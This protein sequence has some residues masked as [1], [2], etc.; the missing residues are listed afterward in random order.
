MPPKVTQFPL[1]L[2]IYK[3]NG[4]LFS[5]F[6]KFSLF[7]SFLKT[8]KGSFP[9][10]HL[11][12]IMSSLWE[13]RHSNKERKKEKKKKWKREENKEYRQGEG[14]GLSWKEKNMDMVN[15]ELYIKR[16][17]MTSI[18]QPCALVV[19][20]RTHYVNSEIHHAWVAFI[21]IFTHHFSHMANT[22][23]LLLK[24]PSKSQHTKRKRGG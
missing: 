22:T 14:G 3:K 23:K 11:T 8:M 13:L 15:V 9:T 1:K 18:I 10:P 7:F 5:M 6:E 17:C 2:S 19:L 21:T 12:W 4:K 24:W 20:L 16:E